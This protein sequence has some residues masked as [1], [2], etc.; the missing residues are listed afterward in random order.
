MNEFKRLKMVAP[1]LT[2]IRWKPLWEGDERVYSFL[3]EPTGLISNVP[4]EWG[5]ISLFRFKKSVVEHAIPAL[6]MIDWT[7]LNQGDRDS[8]TF[9]Q[10]KFQQ[11]ILDA[12]R[13]VSEQEESNGKA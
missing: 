8:L 12:L 5:I 11:A 6:S 13:A 1:G 4:C 9:Y 10:G 7:Q 3:H 2:L